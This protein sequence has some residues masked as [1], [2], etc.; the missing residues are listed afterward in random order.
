[1]LTLRTINFTI[2]VILNLLAHSKGNVSQNHSVIIVFLRDKVSLILAFFS[3]QLQLNL[4]LIKHLIT[5]NS[6]NRTQN[7]NY[8]YSDMFRLT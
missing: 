2:F 3:S 1:M 6:V 5:Y 7:V 8:V 4:P